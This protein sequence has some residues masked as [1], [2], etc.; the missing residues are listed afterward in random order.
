[1]AYQKDLT[2]QVDNYIY[3]FRFWQRGIIMQQHICIIIWFIIMFFVVFIF[4]LV[5]ELLRF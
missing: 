4:L 3:V 5:T 2:K 1:M